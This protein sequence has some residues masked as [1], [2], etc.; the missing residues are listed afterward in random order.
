MRD[1]VLVVVADELLC[2]AERD[3]GIVGHDPVVEPQHQSL[4]LRDDAVLVV[5][6]IADERPTGR[7]ARQILGGRVDA[8]ADRR[9]EQ[10]R[11]AV[12]VHVG[13][14]IRTAA[15]HVVEVEGRRPEIDQR[16]GVVLALEGAGRVE[17]Q[18]MVDELA[19][20]G[21]E[22]R[23]AAF[24]GVGPILG[25]IVRRHGGAEE[26]QVLDVVALARAKGGR[27][28]VREHASERAFE[29]LCANGGREAARRIA[30]KSRH[31]ISPS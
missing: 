20:V 9:A 8:P 26:V 1:H 27:R 29:P 15:I 11:R 22:R 16:V 10:E 30:V 17:G 7:A 6:R 3:A 21:V 18:I 4:Q 12:V 13:L 23:D 24:L 2:I 31:E 14:V 5:A 19:Q 25:R 28:E